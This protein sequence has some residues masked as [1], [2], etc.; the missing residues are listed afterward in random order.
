MNIKTDFL[1]IGTGVAG[2][3]AAIKLQK[4]GKV[5]MV[6]KDAA[7]NCNTYKAAGGVSCVW[8]DKDSFEK[9]VEDTIVAGDYLNKRGIVKNIVSEG[10]KRI[11]EL[12]DW[13]CEFDLMSDGRY[14]LAKEGGHSKRRIFHVKA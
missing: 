11:Q 12:I 4:Y 8:G 14:N 2:L 7:Y 3:S 13:G 9:H 1:I 6:A 5:I 10:P